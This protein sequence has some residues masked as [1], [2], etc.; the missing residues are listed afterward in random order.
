MNPRAVVATAVVPLAA[1]SLGGQQSAVRECRRARPGAMLS[2]GLGLAA[3]PNW[4]T[5]LKQLT[6]ARK[7]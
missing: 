2:S 4:M 1:V 3:V 7:P 5:E 6:A